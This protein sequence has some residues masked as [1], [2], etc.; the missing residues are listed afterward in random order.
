V[1]G[2][3]TGGLFQ[4]VES[5]SKHLALPIFGGNHPFLGMHPTVFFEHEIHAPRTLVSLLRLSDDTLN[6][7]LGAEQMTTVANLG[8]QAAKTAY[9][10]ERGKF[11]TRPM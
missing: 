7:N 10:I 3:L 2:S 1:T 4:T 9:R 8:A 6:P 5:L 11:Q